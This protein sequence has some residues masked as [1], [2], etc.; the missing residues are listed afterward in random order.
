MRGGMP[1]IG[2]GRWRHW[3]TLKVLYT[4]KKTVTQPIIGRGITKKANSISKTSN[5]RKKEIKHNDTYLSPHHQVRIYMD[6]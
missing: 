3:T 2:L 4:Y 6:I 1:K 5:K